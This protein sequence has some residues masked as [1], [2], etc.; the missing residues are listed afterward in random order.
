MGAAGVA[1]SW[2]QV[3]AMLLGRHPGP[4]HALQAPSGTAE[5]F[6]SPAPLPANNA[7]GGSWSRGDLH[8]LLSRF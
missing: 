5:T 7:G 4:Q 2:L 6:L 1:G 8:N 3:G